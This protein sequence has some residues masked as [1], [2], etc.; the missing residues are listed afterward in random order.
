MKFIND[1]N[2][3]AGSSLEIPLG[4]TTQQLQVNIFNH[5]RLVN[6]VTKDDDDY[7]YLILRL[8]VA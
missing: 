7:H 4:A 3:A 8:N 2:E 5:T 6:C 1:E